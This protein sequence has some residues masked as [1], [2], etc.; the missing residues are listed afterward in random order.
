MKSKFL[1]F[2]VL[3]LSFIAMTLT[4]TSCAKD[5]DVFDPIAQFDKE[6]PIIEAYV[7][8][9]YPKMKLSSDTT[10]IWYEILEEGN[11]ESYTY[12]VVDTVTTSYTGK[13]LRSPTVTVRYTGKLVSDNSVFQTNQSEEG[14]TNKVNGFI[15]CWY[16]AF[17]PKSIQQYSIG[18]L[19][20]LGLKKGSKIRIVSPSYYCY[21]NNSVGNIPPNSP[22]YFEIEVV[23]IK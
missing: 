7:K 16:Y 14:L 8:Q 17:V 11:H 10:G 20:Q 3:C 15:S 21:G 23:D 12:K 4:F 5:D 18:G 9:H 22:L 1:K 19:T 6:Q 2:S 13:A